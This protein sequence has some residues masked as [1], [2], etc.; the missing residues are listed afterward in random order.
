MSK[1]N[2]LIATII[3]LLVLC[4][5]LSCCCGTFTLYLARQHGFTF[6]FLTKETPTPSSVIRPTP[7]STTSTPF[8]SPA[9]AGGTLRLPGSE[10]VSLD[11]AIAGDLHSHEYISKI[12]SGLVSLDDDLEV[13]PDIAE[14]W[15]VS[16]DGT[17]YTFY[18]RHDVRFHDGKQV[19]ARDVKYSIERSC[20]PAVAGAHPVASSYLGD[21]VGA[22]D[23]LNGRADEVRGVEVV[24]DYTLRITIDAPKSYFLA[25]LTYPT[26]YV[27]DKANVES[28]KDWTD[29]PNGTGPFRLVEKSEDRIVLAANENYYKGRPLLDKV[30][31]DLRGISSINLYERGDLD[32]ANV[33][34]AD[35]DR[36]LDPNNPLNSELVVVPSLDVWYIAFNTTMP[37]FDDAKVRQAFA[38]A[39]NKKAI[40]NIIRGKMVT[41]ARGILPPGLPGYDESFT[42]IPFDPDKAVALLEE[43]SYGSA[44]KLPPITFTVS[45]GGSLDPETEA[46]V[47]MYQEALG[48]E[49]QVRQVPWGDFLA[50]LN[51][52]RYQ[53][54]KLGW[55]ADYPDPE[56]FLD[57]LF[58][59]QS[60]YNH[61][62]YDD[63]EVNTLL[64]K[65]RIEADHDRRMELYRQVEKRIVDDAV[66]IPLYHGV[67]YVLVKPYVKN[68]VVTPQGFFRYDRAYLETE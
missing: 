37:P 31:Y 13:V 19:T 10:P 50:G 49:I 66:W 65:A 9:H 53:M 43:S 59:G 16:D 23:K 45:G 6:P 12:F 34:A 40:A 25:K 3:V 8:P 57:I 5:V 62:G 28:G 42:G 33:G 64:E 67:D 60:D 29:A 32:V 48:V 2:W 21:I 63:P 1:N 52:R 47:T 15:E 41:P 24:D 46:L 38:Y 36:V 18:L 27:L 39:T 7:G 61:T 35:I 44:D 11:P 68:F 22:I 14:R 30:V 51:E 55:V 56:N 20:D 54:F 58:H 26:S 17:V 4:L